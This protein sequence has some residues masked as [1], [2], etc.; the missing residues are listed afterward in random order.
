LSPE[1][2]PEIAFLGDR[3][4]HPLSD[5]LKSLSGAPDPPVT[6]ASQLGRYP[7]IGPL[8]WE[9]SKSP[10]RPLVILANSPLLDAEDWAVPG[11]TGRT[12]VYRLTGSGPYS[13]PAFRE[14]GPET[15]LKLLVEHLQDPVLSVHVGGES[16][17]VID[18]DNEDYRWD[19]GY[20]I[21]ERPSTTIVHAAIL[22]PEDEAPHAVVKLASGA[23]HQIALTPASP[24]VLP[25][26]VR[27]TPAEGNVLNLWQR[28]TPFWCESCSHTHA[29]GQFRCESPTSGWGLFPSLNDRIT[30]LAYHS[31]L[32]SGEWLLTPLLRGILNLH[33]GRVL[34]NRE[35]AAPEYQFENGK[36]E[37]FVDEASALISIDG[38]SFLI[39]SRIDRSN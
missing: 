33:D 21:C 30:A 16:A 37:P 8:L 25:P 9:L 12:L 6:I 23:E 14:V 35:R 19:D 29:P 7:V 32:R 17:F 11:I 15:E 34:V 28:G 1:S 5:I 10:P 22:H 31:E 4:L 36:W 18:W 20:L 26:V 3:R 24:P 39:R 2:H 38:N 27:L 13:H